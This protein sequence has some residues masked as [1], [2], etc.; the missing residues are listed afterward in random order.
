MKNNILLSLLFLPLFNFAQDSH[1]SCSSVKRF[2]NSM[3]KSNTFTVAQ[4]AQ[5]ERYDVHYYFLNLN[6]TNTTTTLSGSAEI[7]AK[8]RVNLDTALVEFFNTFVISSIEV[9]GTPVTYARQNSA[10]KIPVNKL[11]GE[12]FVIHVNYSGTPP[13]AATNPLGG[14]G[15]TNASS[16]SWGNQVT[17]SLSESFAAYEWFPAKQSLKDKADSCAVWITVPTNCKAG[18]NGV[19][20]QVVDLGN[21]T[22]RFEWKH[23]HPIDYYL[24]SVAVA[25]YVEYNVTANPAGSGPVLIQNFIY[26]N[27]ATLPNFQNDIDETVDFLE[28]YADLFGPYPF[29]DEKYGHCMAPISGGMEHQTMTTQGFFNPTLTC[30]ELAHQWFGDHATCSSWADI[31]VNEGF[32]SYAE[33]IMLENLYPGDQLQDMLDRHDNIMQQQGGSVWVLDSLNDGSI[34]SSRLVYDKGAAIVHT[35][36]FLIGDDQVFYD[37]LKQYQIQYADSV[38]SGVELIAVVE[39]ESG[40]DFSNFT[41]EWYFGEGYPTYS[42]RWNTVGNDLLLEI[43]QTTS[44]PTVTPLFTNDLELLF[45]RSTSAD[46]TIRFQITGTQNQFIISNAAD[47]I[48]ITKIDPNNW[49]CNKSNGIVKDINFT[50]GIEDNPN[51]ARISVFPN[52]SNGPVTIE[53]GTA[54]DYSLLLMDSKGSVITSNEFK[55]STTLDMKTQAQGTYI[56]QVV[57]KSTGEKFNKLIKR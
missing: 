36:R 31:W 34:F 19:L 17:W 57:S 29:A 43:N 18:S 41:E 53:M 54:G 30:H 11:Q 56:L 39:N 28:L 51:K 15:M 9:D 45:D 12:N 2:K 5:T 25:K 27:P 7:H 4:I 20:Q 52:P 38:A 55:N 24:I 50:A 6:M 33:Y 3:A 22:H 44:K 32:A 21:G 37:A 49:I 14:G 23:K 42:V 8:A 16:P 48:N 26:D 10:L 35:L 46:T 40:K 1:G 13:T 47:Y